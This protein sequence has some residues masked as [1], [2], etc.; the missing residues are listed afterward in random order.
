MTILGDNL[1]DITPP[2]AGDNPLPKIPPEVIPPTRGPEPNRFTTCGSN[3][4]PNRNRPTG[5]V[6]SE[7]WH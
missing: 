4:N 7:N 6:L 2:E 5:R 3:P 1:L